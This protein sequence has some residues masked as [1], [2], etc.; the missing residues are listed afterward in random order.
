MKDYIEKY[1][2]GVCVWLG[3]KMGVRASVVRLYFIYVSFVTVGS[4]VIIYLFLAFWLKIKKY[5]GKA[6]S[7]VLG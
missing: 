5:V 4:P 6:V 7:P 1:C 3:Q 2:F